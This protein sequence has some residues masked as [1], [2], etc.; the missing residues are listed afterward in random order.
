MSVQDQLR[1]DALERELAAMTA[2]AESAEQQVKTLMCPECALCASLTEQLR[3][4][5][6]KLAVAVEALK[7]HC[8]DCIPDWCTYTL[9]QIDAIKRGAA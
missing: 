8:G 2:R 7:R 6:A 3:K 5:K 4:V 9:K 1:I